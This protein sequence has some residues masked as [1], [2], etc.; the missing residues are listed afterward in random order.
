M[1]RQIILFTAFYLVTSFYGL[2]AQIMIKQPLF[3]GTTFA[4]DK[5][6]RVFIPPP[7]EYFEKI[8]RKGGASIDIYYSNFTTPA[9]A[10]IE[11]AAAILE[12]LLPD[13]VHITMQATWEIISTSGVL[14]NSS[15]TGYALGQGIEAWKPLAVYPAAL[16]EK[17]AGKKLNEDAE[18]DIELHINSSMNWYLG[19]D[20][21]T[22]TLKYDLVTVALHEMIHGL[23]FFDSFL[24]GSTTGSY[25]VSSLP[26]IYD[27]FIENSSGQKLTNPILFPNPSSALK[28]QLTSGI[29]YF[30]GPVVSTYLS[31]GRSRLYAP[32][33]FE[34]GSS[35]AHL[36]EETYKP[37]DVNTDA[38]M[39]PFIARG[40]AIHNPGKLARAMLGDIGWINTRIIHEP[41]KDT[42]EHISSV[43]INAEIKSDTSYNHGRVALTWSYDDFK[44]SQTSFMTSPGSNDL[45]TSAISI[46]SYETRLSY[47]ISAEDYFLRSYLSPSDTAYP[48]SVY[49]GV[50]TVKPVLTHNPKE[51]YLS[52]VDSVSF[53][54]EATDNIGIDTVIVEYKLND[55]P[56]NSIGLAHAGDEVYRSVLSTKTLP[57][58]GGDSLSYRFI[59][60]DKAASPNQKILPSTG[61]YSVNFERINNVQTSYSTDFEYATGDFLTH[62]FE[63]SKP[64]GFNSFGLHTRHPYESP[65]ENGDS[66]GYTA[67][68]RTPVRFDDSGM[69]I[70]YHEVVL[71]EPGEEGSTFG[72]AYFYDYV[73][74]EGSC[75]FG[76]NWFPLADGYDSRYLDKWEADYNSAIS[77]NN[78]T[79]TGDESMLVK[80]V[81][82]PK[83][84]SLISA[85]DT[86]IIR[87][88]LF[89]DPYAN[90][91][92]W[93]IENLYIG[94]LINSVED[95]TIPQR[96]IFPNPG[97]GRFVISQPE[98]ITDKTL[99]YSIL[100]TTGTVIVSNYTNGSFET[101]IDIS[102]YP[103]GLYLIVLYHQNGIQTLKYYLIK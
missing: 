83:P 68:L 39:T 43:A 67:M 23:G 6:N 50:D 80:H 79:F 100:N 77:G 75:D 94:P 45:Y 34:A 60:I 10:S 103:S 101:N 57:V 70:S 76:K 13:D 78:S 14:A 63:V 93:G 95:V 92:G 2:N 18:G 16:A 64:A 3:T 37:T 102:G 21:K 7:K 29:L 41:A 98:S 62:G 32:A 81:I 30:K 73:I 99:K 71:V 5:V 54:V 90:G 51:Y 72:S 33:T 52:V 89:S 12:A 74:V 9:I 38:L 88:R 69:I 55:G 1:R 58:T 27:V 11:R 26:L 4:S 65:E 20:G 49:V 47:Y 56:L 17:I 97:N 46:P 91:W 40:E 15:A 22:P 35:I 82:F 85:G 19:T 59:G 25:G 87:F 53:D 24:V 42:E 48:H 96:I 66:I 86:M 8:G 61:F 44:T 31:G 36:D 84:S 28:T